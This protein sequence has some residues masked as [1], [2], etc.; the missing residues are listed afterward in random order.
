[1]TEHPEFRTLDRIADA[2][3]VLGLMQRA[4]DYVVLEYGALPDAARVEDFFT[5]CVPGGDLATAIKHGAFQK[6]RL[7]AICDMGFGYPEAGDAY[8]GLVM[9]DPAARGQSLGQRCFSHLREIAEARGAQRLLV[10]V[11]EAN[12]KGRAFWEAMGFTPEKRFPAVKDDPLAHVRW[13]M[14][15]PV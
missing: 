7:V 4:A 2:G 15:R 14:T 9:L 3:L 10:A 11:L 8:I 12:P 5:A 13:R 6:G 1:M